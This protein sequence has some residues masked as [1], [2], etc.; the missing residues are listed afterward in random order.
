MARTAELLEIGRQISDRQ[1]ASASINPSIF[2][3]PQVRQEENFSPEEIIEA[4]AQASKMKEKA[5]GLLLDHGKKST[6]KSSVIIGTL[7]NTFGILPELKKQGT[8]LLNTSN[9][10]RI[11]IDL[12]DEQSKYPEEVVITSK[13]G[14]T[15]YES[16]EDSHIDIILPNMADWGLRGFLRLWR[17]S[18]SAELLEYRDAPKGGR[19]VKSVR[20]ANPT[21]IRQ[22]GEV[23]DMVSDQI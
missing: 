16:S 15:P 11:S 1:N 22:F 10:R 6:D 18:G 5:E 17:I 21:D 8:F 19:F 23:V 2:H 7:M 9:V 12:K 13:G 4:K 14:L 3:R 20:P